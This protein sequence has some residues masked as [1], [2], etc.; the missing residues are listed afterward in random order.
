M[1]PEPYVRGQAFV[2]AAVLV[3]AA[4]LGSP[5]AALISAGVASLSAWGLAAKYRRDMLVA[6]GATPHHRERLD[7]IVAGD[8][9]AVLS[10]GLT[11][12][13]VLVA[14]GF[15]VPD[16]GIASAT[17]ILLAVAVSAVYLS[18]LVDWYLILPRI[19]GQLG[20]RPCRADSGDHER[21]PKTWRET[22]RWWY[23]HRIAAALLLRF[24]LSFALTLSVNEYLDLPGGAAIVAAAALGGF[25]PY[26]AAVPRAFFQAGHPTMIVG[27]TVRRRKTERPPL[28]TFT[29]MGRTI[30]IPGLKRRPVGPHGPR[31]YVFDVALEGVQLVPA[32]AREKAVP[33]ERDGNVS[34][35]RDPETLPLN[36]VAAAEA[37][38]AD[39]AFSG[40]DGQCS[41]VNW[42]CIENPRCFEPK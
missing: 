7:L 4:V 22:T 13:A 30:R 27:R 23:V 36:A 37:T 18:S 34:Y 12:G 26:M 8:A 3:I 33:R 35:E 39:R 11:I 25:A 5:L 16:I 29:V 41:G 24:G 38:P 40:C 14:E 1:S 21:F 31:E 9:R 15:D 19:S 42:Y 32:S 28:R 10:I 17:P 20:A 2:L 6:R